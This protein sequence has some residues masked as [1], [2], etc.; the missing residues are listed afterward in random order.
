MSDFTGAATYHCAKELQVSLRQLIAKSYEA[1]RRDIQQGQRINLMDEAEVLAEVETASVTKLSDFTS[2]Y[3]Q[4]EKSLESLRLKQICSVLA[5][6]PESL[7][8]F[9][10]ADRFDG[11]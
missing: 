7:S 3:Q 1:I 6:G 10:A 11:C 4:M 9:R 8:S 2:D 5:S